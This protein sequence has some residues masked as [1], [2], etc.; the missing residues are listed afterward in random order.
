M[1]P[2]LDKTGRNNQLI[3]FVVNHHAQVAIRKDRRDQEINRFE[4]AGFSAAIGAVDYIGLGMTVR[5]F[6]RFRT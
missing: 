3:G 4:K 5:I 1:H 2:Y 6:S